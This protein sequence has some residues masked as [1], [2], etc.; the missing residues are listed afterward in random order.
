MILQTAG[1]HIVVFAA[2]F[3]L[4]AWAT[5]R[6]PVF[7]AALLLLVAPFSFA[8]PIAHT[9]ITLIKVAL[10]GVACGLLLGQR[11]FAILRDRR[12]L[13][14]L[15]AALAIAAC[16]ALS[17]LQ[18]QFLEPAVRET[19]KAA[20]Y[21]VTLALALLCYSA[22]PD[23]AAVRYA[24]FVSAAIVSLLALG[25][26]FGGAPSAIF[27]RGH[28]VPRIAGPLEGP[29]QLSGYLGLVL[30]V[31]IAFALSG[32]AAVLGWLSI[33]LSLAAL[34][35]TFS[36]AGVLC[37]IVAI[38]VVFAI[39]RRRGNLRAGYAVGALLLVAA[40]V[41]LL[42]GGEVSRFWSAES[43]LAP[44]GLGTRG[45]LWTA[46]WRLWQRHPWLG[47]GAGNYE[48]ELSYAGYPE[49]RTH[50]NSGYLQ[51]LVEQGIPG[52]L[53]VLWLTWLSLST[54]ITARVRGPLTIGVLAAMAGMALHELFDDLMFFPKDGVTFWLLLGI[55]CAAVAV[56]TPSARKSAADAT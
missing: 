20:E 5:W 48:L 43:T 29:N 25:Q 52:L 14:P 55:G 1:A 16:T 28:V 44:N 13:L 9:T 50:A 15:S 6:R 24:I 26:E 47:I 56:A 21:F 23:D 30:P 46:A 37:A 45:E 2:L 8:Y 4:A 18:A 27:V 41:A 40:S 53:A 3:A 22:D 19:L 38:A 35:L 42:I 49:L 54:F 17:L 10:P 32:R 34:V 31:M 51:A 36:R 11:S 33:A 7:G 39:D 12:A